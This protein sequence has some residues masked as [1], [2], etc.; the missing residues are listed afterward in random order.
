MY[1]CTNINDVVYHNAQPMFMEFGPYNYPEAF[2]SGL[3]TYGQMTNPK[4]GLPADTV[5]IN[6]FE[7]HGDDNGATFGDAFIDTK[8][9]LPNLAF[10]STWWYQNNVNITQYQTMVYDMVLTTLGSQCPDQK[11]YENMLSNYFIDQSGISDRFVVNNPITNQLV[12]EALWSDPYYGLSKA[13]N[14]VRWAALQQTGIPL[15]NF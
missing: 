3:V 15:V 4:T 5:T 7:R 10:Y 14:Y 8:M 9:Q 2:L 6:S 13:A 1:N 11:I 12:L